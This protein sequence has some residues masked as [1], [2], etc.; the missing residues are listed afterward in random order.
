MFDFGDGKL[1]KLRIVP[2]DEKDYSD[3]NPDNEEAFSVLINPETVNEKYQ[4]VYKEAA[5]DGSTSA[6]LKFSKIAPKSYVVDLIFDSTGILQDD[7]GLGTNLFADNDT[8]TV[9]EQIEVFKNVVLNYK[10]DLHQPRYCVIL[11]GPT[12]EDTLFRGRLTD[13]DI[14]YTLFHADGTPIR[15]KAKATF[16][17][18]ITHKEQADDQ[19]KNSPDL[20]H[21]R[22]V[23]E[24]DTLPLMTHRIYGDPKYFLEVARVNKLTNFRKLKVGSRIIF[25]PI[26]KTVA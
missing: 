5:A 16:K 9:P 23:K 7:G 2:C 1:E 20:T 25:P 4:V 11:W 12:A 3:F 14:T 10:G 19:Q 6:E 17:E 18:S 22:V 21:V 26:D 8:P 24:G 13:L 15:A